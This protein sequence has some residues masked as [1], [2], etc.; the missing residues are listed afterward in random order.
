ME[1][2][3]SPSSSSLPNAAPQL[4]KEQ[5]DII[6][7]IDPPTKYPFRRG[8]LIRVTAGAGAGKTTTL[9]HLA[10]QCAILGHNLVT[11][12]T[13]T[14]ATAEDTTRKILQQ[15]QDMPSNTDNCKKHLNLD[16]RTLHSASR[17]ALAHHRKEAVEVVDV[18]APSNMDDGALQ[19]VIG[20]VLRDEINNFLQPCF[21][22]LHRRRLSSGESQGLYKQAKKKVIFY[23]FKTLRQF[24]ISKMS[25]EEW[26]DPST[27]NRVYYPAVMYHRDETECEKLGFSPSQY[28]ESV[29]FYAEQAIRL[30]ETHLSNLQTHDLEMK[31]AQLLGLEI[32]GTVLLVD[33]CQDCDACQIA[34]VVHQAVK[35]GKQVVCVGDAAQTIF[36][37]RGAKSQYLMSLD[38]DGC[39]DLISCTLTQSWRFGPQIAHTANMILFA[40]ENSPQ[41]KRQ[42]NPPWI[43]YRIKGAG[44]QDSLVTA[45]SLIERW[46][47]TRQPFTILVCANAEMFEAAL[48]MLGVVS[49]GKDNDSNESDEEDD[50]SGINVNL[51]L[52]DPGTI[53]KFHINGKGENSGRNKFLKDMSKI[54]SL[55]ELYTSNCPMRLKTEDF[56]QFSGETSTWASFLQQVQDRELFQ[57]LAAISIVKRFKDQTIRA[58]NIFRERVLDNPYDADEADVIFSTIHSAKGMEWDHVQVLSEMIPLTCSQTTFRPKYE[59]NF[60]NYGDDVNLMY[61]A[62]TRAKKTLSVPK[63]IHRFFSDCDY[64]H[65]LMENPQEKSC[66]RSHVLGLDIKPGIDL[67]QVYRDIIAPLRKECCISKEDDLVGTLLVNL[68]KTEY[69][70]GSLGSSDDK[71]N[72]VSR[73]FDE[74]ILPDLE[75]TQDSIDSALSG[76]TDAFLD[77]MA[78]GQAAEEATL[79]PSRKRA[80]QE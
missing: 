57:Y 7:Q 1:R 75:P 48:T 61:V 29:S 44:P 10:Q 49:H 67:S 77:V 27:F 52:D 32:P 47:D 15:L 41:T 17:S 14:K 43:P 25:L 46:Y 31:R 76:Q 72:G 73:N 66:S 40:K 80:R 55:S 21:D 8:K 39:L 79:K 53:P 78:H 54:E 56:P 3:L 4:T 36:G 65:R 5:R 68:N 45:D 64:L 12:L 42:R 50:T 28:A 34:W 30:Y 62:C 23:L 16:S 18:D 37:F 70:K 22:N 13:F 33:E 6:K 20:N 59:F 9:L 74:T 11:Y 38:Q 24:C 63:S 58:L 71:G 19:R 2:K 35:Y 60:K 26:K 51:D 69:G